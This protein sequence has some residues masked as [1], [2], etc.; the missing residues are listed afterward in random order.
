MAC[1]ACGIPEHVCACTDAALASHYTTSPPA[2]ISAPT[3]AAG[4][5]G[6][7][8]FLPTRVG[9]NAEQASHEGEAR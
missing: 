5:P 2:A 6:A 3:V 7:R 1:P 4:A 8:C 9:G